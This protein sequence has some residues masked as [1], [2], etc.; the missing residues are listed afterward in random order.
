LSQRRK[1]SWNA[2][3]SSASKTRRNV[4]GAGRPFGHHEELLE[5]VGSPVGENLKRLPAVGTADRAQQG[6][7]QD[8][9]QRVSARSLD[10]RVR[11]F[12]ESDDQR[13]EG[14]RLRRAWHPGTRSR[15]R[16]GVDPRHVSDRY[17]SGLD[18]LALYQ[19][20]IGDNLRR[21]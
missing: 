1:A 3:G 7:G 9:D 8:V 10:A 16:T 11:N 20:A 12:A 18:A 21:P 4:F 6:H 13:V 19:E 14:R 5:K 2:R 17:R 15:W